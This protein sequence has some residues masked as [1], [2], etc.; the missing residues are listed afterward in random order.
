MRKI[1]EI[2]KSLSEDDIKVLR[3]T[4]LANPNF[5][6]DKLSEYEQ[7]RE[8]ERIRQKQESVRKEQE[9]QN[10][11]NNLKVIYAQKKDK[12]LENRLFSK[13]IKDIIDLVGEEYFIKNYF[14]F[15]VNYWERPVLLNKFLSECL[16]PADSYVPLSEE[17]VMKKIKK[18]KSNAL[19]FIVSPDHL[20]NDLVNCFHYFEQRVEDESLDVKD[21]I[22]SR[23]SLIAIEYTMQDILTSYA[24][25]NN[26]FKD[27][28][29]KQDCIYGYLN[30]EYRFLGFQYGEMIGLEDNEIIN[31]GFN[32]SS[33]F[34]TLNIIN[35]II[36]KGISCL[37]YYSS[38]YEN[39][40]NSVNREQIRTNDNSFERAVP[41]GMTIMISTYQNDEYLK[42]LD[43]IQDEYK[44][45]GY[46]FKNASFQSI[47]NVYSTLLNYYK[48]IG[49]VND[50]YSGDCC[51][52]RIPDKYDEVND[53][54]DFRTQYEMDNYISLISL[55]K[56]KTK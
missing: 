5:L 41:L 44:V 7:E 4:L 49:F 37:D 34:G 35:N 30:D 51:V 40:W 36:N 55:A 2:M 8:Q 42:L 45:S 19:K 52:E 50:E 6:S 16:T 25:D 17:F 20:L 23:L 39:Q 11:I 24:F 12:I 31:K 28:Y 1:D 18:E 46:S 47:M 27:N 3:E 29:W 13:R 38:Y 15:V 53:T 33:D 26:E 9:E 43:N 22:G 48:K 21:R 56:S 54:I 32:I 14:Q 10:R